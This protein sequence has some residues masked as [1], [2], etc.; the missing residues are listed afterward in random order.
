MAAAGAEAADGELR[1]GAPVRVELD[2]AAEAA[3]ADVA[4][5]LPELSPPRSDPAVPP[6]FTSLQ[7]DLEV[8]QGPFDLLL[9]LVMREEIDLLEVDLAEIVLTYVDLLDARGEIELEPVTEF[10]VLIAALL[11]LKSRLMLPADESDEGLDLEL[12]PEEAADE[13]LARLLQYHRYNRLAGWLRERFLAESPFRYRSA[14]P[15]ARLRR[16]SFEHVGKVYESE[17]LARAIG[18]LL[19]EPEPLETPHMRAARVTLE[20]RLAVVRALLRRARSFDFDDAVRG[21]DR[22]TECMTVFALLELYK[23]GEA[24]WRQDQTFGPIEVSACA[25]QE[26]A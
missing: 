21:G 5:Q 22:L 17:Q 14:P 1:A 12:G 19:T 13:L 26:A 8:F 25:G 16:V 11:E 9:E 4:A 10:V 2:D 23:L 3:L 24:T 15:P 7:L 20:Q 6:R 18:A